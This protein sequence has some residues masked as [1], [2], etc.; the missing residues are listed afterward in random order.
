MPDRLTVNLAPAEFEA[1]SRLA[2]RD[3]RPM[4]MQARHII[5][6]ALIAAGLLTEKGERTWQID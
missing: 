2:E 4:P 3:L 6:Q 5:R 1:L